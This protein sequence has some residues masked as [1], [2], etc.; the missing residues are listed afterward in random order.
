MK[1]NGERARDFRDP[2]HG[3]ITVYPHEKAIIDTVEFQKAP[4]D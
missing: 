2:V 3:F 1:E 4:S